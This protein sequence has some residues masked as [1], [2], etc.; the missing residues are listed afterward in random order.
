MRR[1]QN[2][3]IQILVVVL[4][5]SC[6]KKSKK[7]VFYDVDNT[8]ES[9]TVTQAKDIPTPSEV[10]DSIMVEYNTEDN[11]VTVPFINRGGVKLI[12]VTINGEFTIPMI[13]DSGCSTTLISIAEARYL[14]EKGCFSADD[15]IGVSQAQIAD[16]SIVENLIINLRQLV[17]GGKI[18]C[19]NVKATVSANAEAPLLLG[20]EVL[21]RTPSYSV[22]NINHVIRFNL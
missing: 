14:Y 4:L 8:P 3:L 10:Y 9:T 12:D 18:V 17:I 6:A 19:F 16:G 13:L 2:V 22:D 11:E 15:I 7:V 21:D 5:C 1:R 20:N